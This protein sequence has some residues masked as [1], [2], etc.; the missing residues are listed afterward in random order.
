[1]KRFYK[2]TFIF[3]ALLVTSI[4][5]CKKSFL[6]EAPRTVTIADLLNSPEDGAQKFIGA[7]YNKLYTWHVHSF[8]WIG[9]SSITSDDADKGSLLGDV[10]TDKDLLDHWTF[11]ENTFS[12]NEVWRGNYEGIGRACYALQ[13]IPIMDLPQQEKDRY[14]GEAKLLRAYFYWNLVRVF[15]GVPKIDHVLE[16]LDEII[17]ATNR[18]SVA[19]IYAFMEEDLNDAIAKLPPTIPASENGRVSKYAAEALLA[20]VSLY[21]QK[22]IQANSMCDN[23]IANTQFQLLDDYSMIWREAGEFSSESIWE[24][25]A[26]GTQPN[27]GVEGWA[28]T[29]YPRGPIGWGFNTPSQDLV[30]TYAAADKRKAGTIIVTGQTMWDGKFIDPVTA[31]NPYYNFKAYFS[32]TQETYDGDN[33]QCNK[34]YRIFRLGEIYLIKAEAENALNNNEEAKKYLNKIR[35]RAG[36]PNTLATDEQ[37][38]DSIY[39]ERRLEMAFEHDRTFDLIRTGRA[40]AVLGP[41]GFKPDRHNVFPIP[42]IQIDKSGNKLQQNPNY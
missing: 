40:E 38:K 15:G 41:L 25:N 9:I 5:S 23:I 29:Q 21:Q 31:I 12:F 34:N 36:L 32:T 1:M 11:D 37:L 39:A 27:L 26:I 13:Y 22:W 16:S 20:K 35:T 10:G 4:I 24:V 19:E 18:A 3:T 28:G 8:P 42:Q 30:D 2:I 14:I 33:W 7:V 6:E 17:A